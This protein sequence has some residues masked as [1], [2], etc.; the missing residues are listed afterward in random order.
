MPVVRAGA[1]QVCFDATCTSECS[2][3]WPGVNSAVVMYLQIE[4]TFSKTA[5]KVSIVD[6]L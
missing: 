5:A 2:T 1:D 6:C 4:S 3:H